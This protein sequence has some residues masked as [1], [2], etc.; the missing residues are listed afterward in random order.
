MTTV[1]LVTLPE[2]GSISTSAISEA[3]RRDDSKVMPFSTPSMAIGTLDSLMAL[4]D[5]L[6][7]INIQVEVRI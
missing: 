3:L 5:D 2:E 1:W 7:K 6:V 4:T